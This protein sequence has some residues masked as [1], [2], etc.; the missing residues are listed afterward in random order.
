MV[1][2]LNKDKEGAAM[3]KSYLMPVGLLAAFLVFCGCGTETPVSQDQPGHSLNQ[4]LAKKTGCKTIQGG[5]LETPDGKPLATGYSKWGYNYQAHIFN[6]SY[7]DYHPYYRPGGAGH[8]WCVANYGDVK[9]VMKWNNAWLSNTD[10][11]GDLKLDR[12]PGHAGYPGSGAWTTNHMQ[13]G[14]G[15]DSWTYFVKIVAAPEDATKV[16]GVWCAADNTEIGPVIWGSFAI[17]Q[18]VDS[19]V[20]ASYVSP[21]GPGLGKF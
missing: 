2:V 11:D 10:C 20:G 1:G 8:E 21:A 13:G 5:E 4:P 7:C 16:G 14:K 17:I 18:Q 15:K 6:G 19:G 3:K 12:H 9:L